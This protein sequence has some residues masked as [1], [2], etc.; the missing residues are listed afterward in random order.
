MS[1]RANVR[2]SKIMCTP[3]KVGIRTYAMYANCRTLKLSKK[4]CWQKTE[5]DTKRR[6][7]SRQNLSDLFDDIYLSVLP[8]FV[9][10]H[11]HDVLQKCT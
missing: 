8:N 11:A 2:M 6:Q 1:V 9:C 10:F 5:K 3:I 4:F 7:S